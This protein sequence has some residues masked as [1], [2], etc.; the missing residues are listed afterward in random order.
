MTIYTHIDTSC[1]ILDN[2]CI[3]V[4]RLLPAINPVNLVVSTR[5]RRHFHF[6]RANI[7]YHNISVESQ[8]KSS[9]QENIT[10]HRKFNNHQHNFPTSHSCRTDNVMSIYPSFIQ[11]GPSLWVRQL[12]SDHS[13]STQW[14][15]LHMQLIRAHT[16]VAR[17]LVL[18]SY[19][20]STPGA[21]YRTS[22]WRIRYTYCWTNN[23][24]P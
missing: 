22:C 4:S 15:I 19:L 1:T 24:T 12:C 3:Y 13:W 10:W 7:T 18:A 20:L 2:I 23:I 17:V 6:F 11:H 8:T 16:M 9:S 14:S 21:L 5:Y